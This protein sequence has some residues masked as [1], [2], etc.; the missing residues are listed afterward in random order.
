M[1][2]VSHTSHTFYWHGCSLISL[3]ISCYFEGI[4]GAQS[5][6]SPGPVVQM[7]LLMPQKGND[8]CAAPGCRN[9]CS[10]QNHRTKQQVSSEKDVPDQI[11]DIPEV[12]FFEILM[13]GDST[14]H[15]L[16]SLR[17]GP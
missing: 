4:P 5:Q 9:G 13:S 2:V 8:Y 14:F 11:R 16:G 7:V 15:H 17:F 3:V 12:F 1:E 6:K 10:V